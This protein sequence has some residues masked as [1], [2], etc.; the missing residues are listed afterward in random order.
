MSTSH[1]EA[2]FCEKFNELG[3]ALSSTF[4][5]IEIIGNYE[6]SPV[7]EA[8]EVYIRGVGPNSMRDSQGRIWLYR[9]N[10]PTE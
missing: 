4:P 9:K 8:Y 5:N 6:Q 2:D 1:E 3:F 7:L 10:E